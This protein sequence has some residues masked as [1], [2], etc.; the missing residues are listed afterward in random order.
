VVEACSLRLAKLMSNIGELPSRSAGEDLEDSLRRFGAD[1]LTP[2]E[3]AVIHLVLRGHDTKS[4]A[5]QLEIATDTVKLH[6][7][8][9]YAKLRVR[10]RGELFFQFL[11]SLGLR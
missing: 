4:I 1:L 6:R 7:R 8:H 2:R 10:S 9:A 11:K 5:S 3:Q